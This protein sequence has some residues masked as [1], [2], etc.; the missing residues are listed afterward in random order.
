MVFK[1]E[2]IDEKKL[3]PSYRPRLEHDLDQPHDRF[4]LEFFAALRDH[5]KSAG[6]KMLLWPIERIA[7]ETRNQGTPKLIAHLE[8][9][10]EKNCKSFVFLWSDL[11]S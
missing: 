4:P 8:I 11:P 5:D 2:E 10:E 7:L 6:I 9:K 1:V 3:T